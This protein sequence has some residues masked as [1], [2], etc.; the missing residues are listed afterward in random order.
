MQ[1]IQPQHFTLSFLRVKLLCHSISPIHFSIPPT[2]LPY[3]Q[4]N[5]FATISSRN[6]IGKPRYRAARCLVCW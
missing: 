6:P 3:K 2:L 1:N 5:N 4:P